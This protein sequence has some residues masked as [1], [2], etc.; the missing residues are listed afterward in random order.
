MS[1][2]QQNQENLSKIGGVF[3]NWVFPEYLKYQHN[4]RWYVAFSIAMLGLLVFSL[5]TLN[6]LFAVIIIIFSVVV[7]L[8]DIKEP[9]QISFHIGENGILLG[10]KF[11][12]YREFESFWLIYDPKEV[13]NLYFSSKSFIRPIV[14]IPLLDQNPLKIREFLLQ[15]LEED[16]EKEEESV[17]DQLGRRFKI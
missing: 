4:R 16:L 6:F 13:K 14:S 12:A 7:F 5:V 10:R 3:A 11:F 15:Y 17:S 2:D 1:D 8:H 9:M